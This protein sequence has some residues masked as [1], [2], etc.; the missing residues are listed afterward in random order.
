MI[1]ARGAV[2]ACYFTDCS[3]VATPFT[4]LTGTPC[5]QLGFGHARVS[6]PDVANGLPSGEARVAVTLS[7][8]NNQPW[9]TR[10]TQT[11]AYAGSLPAPAVHEAPSPYLPKLGTKL[12]DKPPR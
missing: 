5:K 9:T 11:A 8:V 2:G 10:K 7:T 4:V 6:R 12:P 1:C 3:P